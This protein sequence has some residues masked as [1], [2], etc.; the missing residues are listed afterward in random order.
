MDVSTRTIDSSLHQRIPATS[1]YIV[2]ARLRSAK[3]PKTLIGRVAYES[4]QTQTDR[5][6]IRGRSAGSLRF[7]EECFIDIEGLLHTYR[8]PDVYGYGI[9]CTEVAGNFGNCRITIGPGCRVKNNDNQRWL[10]LVLLGTALLLRHRAQTCPG[11]NATSSEA[12]IP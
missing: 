2:R 11:V 10:Y 5:F 3:S 12:L 8:M 4:F 1:G 6:G 9:P 7:F